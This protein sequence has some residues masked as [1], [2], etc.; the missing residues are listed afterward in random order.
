MSEERPPASINGK[1][2]PAYRVWYSQSEQGKAVKKR[3]AQS[4]KGKECQRR[5]YKSAKGQIAWRKAREKRIQKDPIS[6]VDKLVTHLK[7]AGAYNDYQNDDFDMGG[8]YE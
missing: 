4:A 5:F 8:Q 1:P 2:N 7:F 3:Y 6:Y